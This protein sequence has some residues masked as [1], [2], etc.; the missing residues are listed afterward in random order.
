MYACASPYMQCSTHTHTHL[1]RSTSRP[2]AVIAAARLAGFGSSLARDSTAPMGHSR[3]CMHVQSEEDWR[4]EEVCACACPCVCLCARAYGAWSAPPV[5]V[6]QDS[7]RRRQVQHIMS[8]QQ[9]QQRQMHSSNTFKSVV[10]VHVHVC[11]AGLWQEAHT[12]DLDGLKLYQQ[13]KRLTLQNKVLSW[14][15]K[16]TCQSQVCDDLQQ[17][18]RH[19]CRV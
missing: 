4:A 3:V 7:C 6:A 2:S 1:Q 12:F 15:I 9:Q 17:R 19:M 18:Q 11:A 13:R 16:G 5:A 14:C 10:C 8:R